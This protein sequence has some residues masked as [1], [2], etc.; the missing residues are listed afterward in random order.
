M[1]SIRPTADDWLA[2]TM[3]LL[4]QGRAWPREPQSNW[5]KLLGVASEERRLRHERALVLLDVESYPPFSVELLADWEQAAGLP[6]PC[7]PAPGTLAERRSELI[8]RLFA[9]HVPTPA[10]M[11]ALAAQAGWHIEIKERRD[12]VAGISHAGDPV[13]ESDF[14]WTVTVLDQSIDFFHAGRNVAGD[15]LW[16]FPDLSTLERVLRRANPAHLQLYFVVS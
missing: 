7:R 12:F 4:P 8:D 5:G 14:E 13:G 1:T 6:D 16:T 9:D 2:A 3:D 10:L 15:P 11:I